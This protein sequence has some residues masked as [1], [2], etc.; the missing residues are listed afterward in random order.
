[1][2]VKK[3]VR[4]IAL[5]I[6]AVVCIVYP[7]YILI[8]KDGFLHYQCSLENI[9]N[10]SM[11]TVLELAIW[12]ALAVLGAKKKDIRWIVVVGCF[13]CYL[14]VMFLPMF[15]AASYFLLTVLTGLFFVEIAGGDYGKEKLLI[16]YFLG[17]LLM[18]VLYAIL[19]LFKIG[20][21]RNIQIADSILLIILLIW[22]CKRE[23]SYSGKSFW[24][25]CYVTKA[26]YFKTIVI[27]LFVMLAVGRAN[28][29]LD[30]DSVWYGLRSA[31]AL[32]NQTGIYDNLK[33]VGCVYTYPK[34]LETY[35]LPLSGFD[36]YGFFY[37]GNIIFMIVILYIAYKISRL[38]LDSEKALWTVVFLSA[39]P[40]IMNMSI[41]AKT[42]ILT[43]L[44]QLLGIYFLLL[45]FKEKKEI[46]VGMIISTYI[47]AQ[48]LK[49]TAI[50]FSTTI[51]MVAVFV[52]IVYKVKPIIGEKSIYL[53]ILSV[54]DLGF[55]WYRTYLLTGIPAT[56]VW[57][58]AFR[59]FGMTDKYP[60]ASGQISQ[61]RSENL[62]SAQVIEATLVRLKEFFFAPNSADTDH[63]I[64]AWGTTLCTFLFCVVVLDSILN[65]KIVIRKVKKSSA[66]CCLGLLFIGE[67]LGCVMSLWLL[68][69]PDG[70]Y[71]MLYYAADIIIGTIY[72]YHETFQ[73]DVFNKKVVTGVLIAFLPVNIV[74]TGAIT[75]AW[76]G[77]LSEI[78]FVNRG[79]F[80]HKEQFKSMMNESG[81]INIYDMVTEDTTNKLLV[82]GTHPDVERF[83]CVVESELDVGFWGNQELLSS[84]ENFMKFVEYA[85]YDYILIFP[86]YVQKDSQSYMNLSYLIDNGMIKSAINENNYVL[87]VLGQN[88]DTDNKDTIKMNFEK[89]LKN[90]E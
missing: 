69:K 31:Y 56:S 24:E 53:I 72:I 82:F 88:M 38:F 8:I 34:G 25:K 47:F 27:M 60:Y 12:G 7:I 70:N 89:A 19:S 71:F 59:L 36:S 35:L 67:F 55:I 29:S 81:C 85:E 9:P 40:G 54:I 16:S 74:F 79:Y 86:D 76:T 18:T 43:L 48:T 2:G 73:R 83:P 5:I 58:K 78:D 80:N 44:V 6:F 68:S 45:F 63:V 10:G 75:W 84:C 90:N 62:F 39:I 52:C 22:F 57:G 87:F 20:S 15:V 23:K 13:F 41:T 30:Y 32:D 66:A 14:H 33:L 51:L 42:D 46:Y 1:M 3:R 65:L 37:A 26:T 50:I 64:I 28:N 61:F 11:A 4:N 77:Q 49:T 21:I 17:M